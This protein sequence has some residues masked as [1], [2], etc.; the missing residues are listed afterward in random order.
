M[1][2]VSNLFHRCY[3]QGGALH[4]GPRL[5]SGP[6]GLPGLSGGRGQGRHPLHCRLADPFWHLQLAAERGVY[7]H[8]VRLSYRPA[9]DTGVFTGAQPDP[10]RTLGLQFADLAGTGHRCHDHLD[11]AGSPAYPPAAFCAAGGQD[12]D[13][14]V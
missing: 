5:E 10:E 2:C 6:R 9:G 1:D 7:R 3:R 14:R 12:P 8:G 11:V 13:D 4:Q